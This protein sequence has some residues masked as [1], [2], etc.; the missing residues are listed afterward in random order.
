MKFVV[1]TVIHNNLSFFFLS[2]SVSYNVFLGTPSIIAQFHGQLLSTKITGGLIVDD[3]G[4]I[5]NLASDKKNLLTIFH[6]MQI[7]INPRCK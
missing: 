2:F 5:L 7:I 1:L 6:K 3:I 4:N